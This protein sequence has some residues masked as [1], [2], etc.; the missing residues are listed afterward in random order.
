MSCLPTGTLMKRPLKLCRTRPKTLFP[1]SSPR[2]RGE[3]CLGC[4]LC[5]F[6]C[7][8]GPHG[9]GIGLP[10]AQH[11]LHSARMSAEQC[12]AHPWLNNL[13]EKAKRCNRRLKSQILLKK[14]LMKRRWK[15]PELGGGGR[16]G[17]RDARAPLPG[18][19]IPA[20]PWQSLANRAWPCLENMGFSLGPGLAPILNWS[21]SL[22]PPARGGS[23]I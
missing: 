11:P 18:S 10:S 22:T 21:C 15:V 1:I 3:A 5:M 12:L 7:I 23:L 19:T 17:L 9:P 14:Y 6:K 4:G 13:A 2:T 8:P 20:M 16:G